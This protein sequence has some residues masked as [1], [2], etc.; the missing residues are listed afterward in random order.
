MSS[1]S[2]PEQQIYL[3]LDDREYGPYSE[4][5]VHQMLRN[6]QI[7]PDTE[8]KWSELLGWRPLNDS[9]KFR[10]SVPG[11]REPMPAVTRVSYRQEKERGKTKLGHRVTLVSAIWL[12]CI[13]FCA[14]VALVFPPWTA[15]FWIPFFIGFLMVGLTT[16]ITFVYYNKFFS[17]DWAISAMVIFLMLSLGSSWLRNSAY[18]SF[19]ME[20]GSSQ[21]EELRERISKKNRRSLISRSLRSGEKIE[22]DGRRGLPQKIEK[23]SSPSKIEKLWRFVAYFPYKASFISVLQ[24]SPFLVFFLLTVSGIKSGYANQSMVG[25]TIHACLALICLASV[26]LL[27]CAGRMGYLGPIFVFIL[28]IIYWRLG[29]RLR[30]NRD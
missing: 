9:E 14:F 6:G 12:T 2:E 19:T 16:A 18:P 10:S 29:G 7:W 11:G 1:V 20:I 25:R 5:Q 17:K 3:K 23:L 4:D 13:Y 15:S 28:W 21:H 22:S 26:W 24:Y 30:L 27:F 8:G